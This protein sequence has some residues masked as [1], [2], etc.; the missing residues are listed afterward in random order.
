[1]VFFNETQVKNLHEKEVTES[2][3]LGR[4]LLKGFTLATAEAR[5]LFGVNFVFIFIM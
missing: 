5:A 2:Q 3:I 4:S 1:M